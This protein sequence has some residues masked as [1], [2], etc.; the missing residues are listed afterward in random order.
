[1]GNRGSSYEDQ[2]QCKKPT[3]AY[4]RYSG[5]A[6]GSYSHHRNERD[7]GYDHSVFI[8]RQRLTKVREIKLFS[9]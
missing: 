8:G 5:A 9:F 7:S 1:M 3:S 2:Y 4:S 6:M